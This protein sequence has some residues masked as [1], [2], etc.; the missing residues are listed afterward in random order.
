[1]MPDITGEETTTEEGK[2]VRKKKKEKK[3]KVMRS[4]FYVPVAIAPLQDEKLFACTCAEASKNQRPNPNRKAQSLRL[5]LRPRIKR[6]I[7]WM[8]TFVVH[9]VVQG[10]LFVVTFVHDPFISL[11]PSRL[12]IRSTS[13]KT[14]GSV[15]NAVITQ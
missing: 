12:S 7:L 5:K 14:I 10:I 1:M 8:R 3:R 15:V 11:V 13:L 4:E 2:I 6:R 9:A